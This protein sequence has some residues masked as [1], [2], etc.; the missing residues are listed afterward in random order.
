MQVRQARPEDLAAAEAVR[1]A[2]WK[3]AYRG[4]VPDAYLDGLA[5]TDERVAWLQQRTETATFLALD[6]EQP[7]GMAVRGP[8]RDEDRYGGQE[9]YALYVLPAWWGSGAAQL[10]WQAAQPFTSLWVLE[11]NARA[12]RF[13]ERNGFVPETTKVIEVGGPLTEVRYLLA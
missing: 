12:R 3:K 13:Y 1:I 6:G 8:C 2:T 10:L 11:G 7:V 9:L 4:L 5:V